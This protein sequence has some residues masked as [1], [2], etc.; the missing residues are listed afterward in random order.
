MIFTLLLLISTTQVQIA[1]SSLFSTPFSSIYTT[2]I[3]DGFTLVKSGEWLLRAVISQ[4]PVINVAETTVSEEK[5]SQENDNIFNFIF[6]CLLFIIFF[7]S[8]NYIISSGFI[9]K[10]IFTYMI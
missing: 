3:V 9:H 2:Y 4:I 8:S 6:I 10:V 5:A 1:K 7:V